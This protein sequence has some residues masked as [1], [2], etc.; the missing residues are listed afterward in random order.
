MKE[1]NFISLSCT[2]K[3][4][5]LHCFNI[6]SCSQTFGLK[7]YLHNKCKLGNVLFFIA[8]CKS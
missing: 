5:K 4:F 3:T 6:S 1:Q 2:M 7:R 8:S